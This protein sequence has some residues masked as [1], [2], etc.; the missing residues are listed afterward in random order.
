ML[1]KALM[2]MLALAMV[3]AFAVTVAAEDGEEAVEDAVP[4]PIVADDSEDKGDVKAGVAGVATVLGIA[5]VA[6]A[7]VLISVKKRK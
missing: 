2:L 4:A 1:K 5:A 6:G 7:G 3:A